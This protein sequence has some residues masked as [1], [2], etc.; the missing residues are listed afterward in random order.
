[1]APLSIEEI[2]LTTE[3][4]ISR[5]ACKTLSREMIEQLRAGGA[6]GDVCD[7]ALEGEAGRL[8]LADRVAVNLVLRPIL[9]G[10]PAP[11]QRIAESVVV[12]LCAKHAAEYDLDVAN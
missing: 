5:A 3:S 12:C 8:T 7:L 11:E 10:A 9:C 4:S 1:M 2:D 6:D